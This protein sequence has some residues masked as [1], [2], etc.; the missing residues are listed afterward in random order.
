MDL[1]PIKRTRMTKNNKEQ[2]VFVVPAISM[3]TP[4]GSV[5]KLPHPHGNDSLIFAHLEKAIEAIDRAGFGYLFEDKQMPASEIP[6]RLNTDL[7]TAIDP[8]LVMLKDTNVNAVASAAYALGEIRAEKAI[9]PL[10]D[11]IG[12]DDI[13]IRS[14]AVE[15]LAKIGDPAVKGLIEALDD[16]NWVARNSAA[17]ALGEMVNYRGTKVL[18]AL[19]PL[20]N[21]LND[22]NWIVKSSAATAIG[23][24]SAFIRESQQPVF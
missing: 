3:K 15:A 14:K 6:N 12:Q 16:E 21:R 20:I 10:L 13:A 23:K 19:Q 1:V 4:D 5:K 2:E 17:I 24:I 18:Y 9:R 8:L 7:T 11:I 22:S